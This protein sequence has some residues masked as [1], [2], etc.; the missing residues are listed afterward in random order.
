MQDRKSHGACA[1]PAHCRDDRIVGIQHDRRRI[2]KDPRL[3]ASVGFDRI[4]PV[5]V[6][7]G[8]VKH[9]RALQLQRG[10]GLQLE[11]RQFQH[12]Q[13]GNRLIEQVKSG[14]AEVA[15]RQHLSSGRSRHV[16]DHAG[17]RALAIR[18]GDADHRG[19][20]RTGEQFDVTEDLNATLA[21]ALGD[22]LLQRDPGR[23]QQLRGAVQQRQIEAAQSKVELLRQRAQRGKSGRILARIRR[24]DRN[25]P[26][27]EVAY[28]RGARLS[29]THDDAVHQRIFKVA[30]PAR[31]NTK[32]MIQKRTITR[33]SGQPLSSK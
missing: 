10:G 17:N 6:V 5:H 3:R 26:L 30:R 14:L 29:E 32:L 12:V 24:T 13:I 33:G 18:A 31:T 7:S 28:A 15:A 1:T 16:R 2:R 25:T 27:R 4:V 8:N 19:P 21:R 23:H 9:D 22:R 11:A 20:D